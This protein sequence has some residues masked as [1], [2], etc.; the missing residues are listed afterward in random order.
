MNLI[1]PQK[2]FI[3]FKNIWEHKGKDSTQHSLEI[4]DKRANEW[5]KELE[6]NNDF[7]QSLTQRVE[8]CRDFLI[9]KGLLG[10]ND[11]VLDIGCGTG[12]FVA[13]FAKTSNSATG[14]DISPNM[15]KL[16]ERYSKD[17]NIT[18][19]SF[20]AGDFKA[21]DIQEY[22]WQKKFDLVFASITPAIGTYECLE[23]MDQI[24]KGYCFNSSFINWQDDIQNNIAKELFNLNEH[25]TNKNHMKWFYSLFNL[26]LFMGY[27]PITDYYKKNRTE[28]LKLDD[29][30]IH[31]Y[32]KPYFKKDSEQ[33]NQ[34]I[35]NLVQKY[36]LSMTDK[37]GYFTRNTQHWYG[38]ILWNVNERRIL[39]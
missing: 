28:K 16:A 35:Y 1:D 17:H 39:F 10:N 29:L 18:N 12:R 13:E 6:S 14:L 20:L 11:H 22:N 27:L 32:A 9:S 36:L 15:V 21:I 33:Q 37:D 26:L 38:W 8:A 23:K 34:E 3:Y 30:S 2:D 7:K 4:W 19:T 31:Y 5:E 25:T 24:S